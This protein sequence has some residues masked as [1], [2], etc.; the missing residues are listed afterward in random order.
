MRLQNETGLPAG[1]V[2]SAWG[3]HKNIAALVVRPMFRVED[4]AL[5]RAPELSWPIGPAPKVTPL[6]DLP[7]DKPMLTG[8]VDVMVHGSAH[9]SLP[10]SHLRVELTV[11]TFFRALDVFGKRVWRA[12]GDRM[13]PSEA[14]PFRCMPLDH[15]H[16]HGGHRMSD[17]GFIECH[18]LNPLGMGWSE[19][20]REGAPVC[21]FEAAWLPPPDGSA[22][23]VMNATD[24]AEDGTL[25]PL[26]PLWLN[27]AHPSLIIPPAEAP[28]AGA[29]V[30]L[31]G[32]RRDGQPLSFE[33]PT[34]ELTACVRLA[35]RSHVFPLHL[36][37][38]A[39][40]AEE[41]LVMLSY[42]VVFRYRIV[43]G[44][45]RSATLLQSAS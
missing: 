13:V 18:P 5:R 42:R 10:V 26:S 22:H 2:T 15:A 9:A 36:D 6:G 29:A 14:E 27:E 33:L 21:H 28:E 25:S 39:I 38:L 41:G 30:S 11:G 16:A 7:G 23:A 31:T 43:R 45:S 19:G 4:G 12:E 35:D 17:H 3:R 24:V 37:Q 40:M 44:E 32:V 34:W 8:G 20:E 1:L